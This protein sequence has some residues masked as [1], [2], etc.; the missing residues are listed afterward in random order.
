MP[1]EQLGPDKV[2][3]VVGVM[4][5][6]CCNNAIDKILD[7]ARADGIREKKEESYP[8]VSM[9]AQNSSS[10][11]PCQTIDQRVEFV[12][13]SRTELGVSEL[14]NSNNRSISPTM[15]YLNNIN[16]HQ[17]HVDT[18][19]GPNRIANVENNGI[20]DDT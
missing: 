1:S 12:L 5:V 18:G 13:P 4:T 7:K 15:H 20:L 6:T 3:L 17:N 9:D 10:S 2:N 8:H 19:K 14:Q 16:S 11:T